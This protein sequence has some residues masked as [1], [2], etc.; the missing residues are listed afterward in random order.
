MAKAAPGHFIALEGIEGSGKTTQAR[1]LGERLRRLG[2]DPLMVREPGG[3]EFAE[4]VRNLLLHEPYELNAASELFL[5]QASR[6]DLTRRLI[7]P[8]LEAGRTVIADRFEMTSR[9]YQGA[10]RGLPMDQ[11]RSAIALAT[12]GTVPEL[13]I[14]LDATLDEGRARQAAQ[15]KSADRLERESRAFHEAVAGAYAA[16]QGPDV[17][18]VASQGSPEQTHQAVWAV[19]TR[20]FPELAGKP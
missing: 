20:R 12:G 19:V 16:E 14:V 1:L 10:A 3:T 7:R 8:A 18:H 9:T 2:H 13:Y 5:F 17:E 15:G 4:Q 11:V 6:A